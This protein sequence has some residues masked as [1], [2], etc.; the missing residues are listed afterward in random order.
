MNISR[1]FPDHNHWHLAMFERWKV[2]TWSHFCCSSRLG[3]SKGAHP[4]G[5]ENESSRI[6]RTFF[7]SFSSFSHFV[8]HFFRL[9]RNGSGLRRSGF[10][11]DSGRWP[12]LSPKLG[13]TKWFLQVKTLLGN[14]ELGTGHVMTCPP[15]TSTAENNEDGC[16][17]WAGKWGIGAIV[18]HVFVNCYRP[19]MWYQKGL[20]VMVLDQIQTPKMTCIGSWSNQIPHVATRHSAGCM[21]QKNIPKLSRLPRLSHLQTSVVTAAVLVRERTRVTRSFESPFTFQTMA[22][23]SSS[24]NGPASSSVG[25]G[26]TVPLV[27]LVPPVTFTSM[28][29]YSR[30][31]CNQSRSS[32]VHIRNF[33]FPT[34][35][36][37]ILDDTWWF[38]DTHVITF[39]QFY[40]LESS[41]VRRFFDHKYMHTQGTWFRKC[42]SAEPFSTWSPRDLHVT[43]GVCFSRRPAASGVTPAPSAITLWHRRQLHPGRASTNVMQCGNASGVSWSSWMWK[44]KSP[45]TLCFS[46]CKVAIKL[47]KTEVSPMIFEWN[48]EMTLWQLWHI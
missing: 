31:P 47:V 20:K 14:E 41:N 17:I 44:N 15:A 40:L 29:E 10:I 36:L 1:H 7:E 4:N 37:M 19:Q 30:L 43:W 18:A 45:R 11:M 16:G 25:S 8:G 22:E 13:T 3:L 24:S 26:E 38:D 28:A 2:R 9:C 12:K 32:R 46:C 5:R 48:I 33:S 27:P 39:C 23:G 6:F 21:R 42:C 35:Y 34:W